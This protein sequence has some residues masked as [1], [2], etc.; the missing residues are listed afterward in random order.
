MS[1]ASA[2][3]P[4]HWG[5]RPIGAVL[6]LHTPDLQ[7]ASQQARLGGLARPHHGQLGI[8]RALPC[9][10]DHVRRGLAA[11]QA[12]QNRDGDKKLVHPS[13]QSAHTANWLTRRVSHVQDPASIW[14]PRLHRRRKRCCSPVKLSATGDL[15]GPCMPAHAQRES[16]SS[17]L[18]SRQPVLLRRSWPGGSDSDD[19]PPMLPPAGSIQQL[20]PWM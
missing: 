3:P 19:R 20:P 8:D 6:P 4:C 18:S 9:L 7:R 10:R 17:S 1:A 16:G 12:R 5:Q 2:C 11:A 15:G 14:D 13:G